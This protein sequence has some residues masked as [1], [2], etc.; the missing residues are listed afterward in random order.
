MRV[1]G[2]RLASQLPGDL[3]RGIHIYVRCKQ[4]HYFCLVA[5]GTES[6]TLWK[7]CFVLISLFPL[8]YRIMSFMNIC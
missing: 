8:S 3:L 1:L 5:F 2:E 7:T 6:A 4:I